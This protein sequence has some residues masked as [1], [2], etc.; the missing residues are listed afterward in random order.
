MHREEI[1]F[2]HQR[3]VHRRLGHR[4]LAGNGR[5]PTGRTTRLPV[6][7]LTT[8][9]AR[10]GQDHRHRN[11]W[12]GTTQPG[13]WI[14]GGFLIDARLRSTFVGLQIKASIDGQMP[15]ELSRAAV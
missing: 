1:R 7:H 14:M 8:G 4:P 9:V 11:M 6:P 15:A 5:T 13:F 3:D 2:T 10:I 12:M